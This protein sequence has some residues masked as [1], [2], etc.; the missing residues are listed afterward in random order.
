MTS[1]P[2]FLHR[3]RR[4]PGSVRLADALRVLL[5]L[6]GIAAWCALTGRTGLAIPAM[7]G[8]I[9][10]ALAETDDP[11]RHR[12][13]ALV[14]TLTCFAAAAFGVQ[15]LLPF[16]LP[17]AAALGVST[18]A[19]VMLGAISGR[20]ASIAGGTL[21]LAVYMMIAVD[22]LGGAGGS[23]LHQ[24]LQLL[25]GA[26]W[27]GALSLLWAALLP[28]HAVRQA[29]ASVFDTLADV[30]DAKAAL[31]V[32]M[33]GTDRQTLQ[34][35][36]A[37]RNEKVVNALN[38]ARLTLID[39]LG[40]R[41]PR[42]ALAQRLQ[43]Y[44]MV[45]DVHERVSSA[46]YP[47]DAL[48]EAFFHSDVLFRCAHVL[49]Q[50]ARRCRERAAMLQLRLSEHHST[51]Q[52]DALNELDSAIATLHATAPASVQPLL[53]TLDALRRN[54]STIGEQLASSTASAPADGDDISLQDPGPQHLADAWARVRIQCTPRSFRFRHALRLSL[55]LM[56]GYAVLRLLHPQNGYW[57]LLTT[58]LV[59]QP[60]YH[61]TRQRLMQRVA[62]TVIGLIAGWAALR[63]LPDGLWQMSL[64][65][66]TG[67]GFFAWRHRRYA[68]ATAMI[69]LFVVLCFAQVGRGYE[70]MWPRLLDT[71][72]GAG[73]A[74]LAIRLIWPDWQGRDLRDLLADTLQANARYL[75]QIMA[76]YASGRRDD[77]PYRIARR[78]AHNAD[79]AL[80]NVISSALREPA[81]RDTGRL[82]RARG[83]AH[84]L[85]G[86][87]SMLGVHR[88][89]MANDAARAAVIDAGHAAAAALAQAAGRLRAPDARIEAPIAPA[90]VIEYASEAAG[91]E[92][93]VLVLAQLARLRDQAE[94]LQ[95]T[96]AE[97]PRQ[98]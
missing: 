41:R 68:L 63:L 87:I 52:H 32:P 66:L 39:R 56:L 74:A 64:V 37:Q 27:Y 40:A 94:R 6:G 90:T 24:P 78:D 38:D 53:P 13:S 85:L 55:A 21:I 43:Q 45:Q 4:L 16:A 65:A 14:I 91:D 84:G 81:Q 83:A 9:A 95:Q 67:V 62:G 51:E 72:I 19:L 80:S 3:W 58:L 33:R 76:Q 88:Q 12:L 79:A 70:V 46:H 15:W 26:A 57:I 30:F 42:G 98:V 48:A 97:R 75:A 73:I 7:L 31:F 29:L 23:L 1:A 49:Q 28:Q 50:H 69:T 93:G 10:C 71:L 35:A 25:A 61:A 11:W 60:S 47:Y 77:L 36:L 89:R 8:A 44:F 92:V 17:F 82:L 54:L 2:S 59:C 22:A 96:V 20:Y 18:F 86:Q 34:M 5:A